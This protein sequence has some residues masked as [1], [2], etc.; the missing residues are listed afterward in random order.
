MPSSQGRHSA[1]D[2]LRATARVVHESGARSRARRSAWLAIAASDNAIPHRSV[3]EVRASGRPLLDRLKPLSAA[4]D[5]ETSRAGRHAS[6]TRARAWRLT[7]LTGALAFGILTILLGALARTRR[8][9]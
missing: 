7:A 5:S 8:A 9:A 2:V 4:V 6:A 1:D 3:A